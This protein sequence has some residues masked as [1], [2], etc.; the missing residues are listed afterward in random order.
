MSDI[1]FFFIV[2]FLLALTKVSAE[3]THSQSPQPNKKFLV[4]NIFIKG[5]HH[6]KRYI[7]LREI[8]VKKG[9]SV[10]LKTLSHRLVESRHN[11]LNRSLFNFVN[12]KP[13]ITDSNR[14]NIYV[15]VVERWYIWPIPIIK[16]TDLNFNV[17]WA[18]K[19]LSRID[20]GIDLKVNNFRGRMETLTLLLQNGYNKSVQLSWHNPYIN[21]KETWGVGFEGGVT[22]NHEIDY[23][24]VNNKLVFFGEVNNF[25]RK[26]MFFTLTATY[27]PGYKIL[28]SFYLSYN[29][30]DYADTLLAL[31]PSFA[32]GQSDFSYLSLRY[33]FKVDYRDYKAYPLSGYYLECDFHQFGL[34]IFKS[35]VNYFSAY[36]VYD[37]YF[38]IHR[39]WYFAYN[40]TVK[41]QPDRYRPHFLE[42]GLG[43]EPTTLRGYQLYVVNGQWMTLFHSNLKYELVPKRIIQ[44]PYIHS[45]KFGK[46]FYSIYANLIFDAGYI[47][48]NQTYWKNPLANRFIFGT[49]LGLDFVT[50]Y[51]M[52]FGFEYTINR[53][54]QKNF[55]ISLVAPI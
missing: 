30:F 33:N 50:Y 32:Y 20:Y 24:T 49:G 36:A 39:P 34:G 35:G 22:F 15:S 18:K 55:F 11:L 46:L 42:R 21:K 8:E 5:N 37:R 19:E 12:I 51:D 2:L 52:V 38:P 6:T 17:W 28:N 29:H 13:E 3:N 54:N 10:T 53:E 27:R 43:Y 25:V 45:E 9:D 31:N 40:F 41:I 14:V 44:L 47:S 4:N 26:N 16:Y 1:K 48:D 7:I 23:N